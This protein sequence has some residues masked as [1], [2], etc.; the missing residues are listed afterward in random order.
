[1]KK[2]LLTLSILTILFSFNAYSQADFTFDITEHD[3]GS[4]EEKDDTL[5]YAFK[6]KNT[7]SEP[8]VISNITTSCE[9]TLADWVK[10]PVMPGQSGVIKAGYKYKGKSGNFNKNL[11]VIANTMPAVTYLTIKGVILEKKA[12]VVD[13]KK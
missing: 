2:Y 9:C 3:F 5:W 12:A 7:G 10:K 6:F 1:M 4:V 13:K 8:L 11:T